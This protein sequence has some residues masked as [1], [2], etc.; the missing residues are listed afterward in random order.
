MEI[1]RAKPAP[2]RSPLRC[3]GQI[4]IWKA[5]LGHLLEKEGS[6]SSSISFKVDRPL[7]KHTRSRTDEAEWRCGAGCSDTVLGGKIGRDV[8]I[9]NAAAFS[10]SDLVHNHST[11][12]PASIDLMNLSWFVRAFANQTGHPVDAYMGYRCLMRRSNLLSLWRDYIATDRFH[13]S[14]C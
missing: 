3:C 12:W 9:R 6:L 5:A 11:T 7:R 4:S 2:R 8:L 14:L 13:L 10:E 1:L